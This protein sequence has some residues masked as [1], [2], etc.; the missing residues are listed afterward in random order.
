MNI[1]GYLQ[2]IG[3]ALMVPVATLPAAAILV[4]VGYWI[5]PTGWGSDNSLAALLISSGNAILENMAILF[6]VG[7]A[8]GM[9]KDKD[10]A[11]ALTGLVGFM[12][13]LK[14]CS[15]AVIAMIKNI[16]V[17]EVPIA[18]S[19]I[20]NQFIGILVG[21]ISAE[22]YNRYSHIEL[23][24]AL[25]FF[26]GRRLVPIL[27]SFLM[28]LLSFVLMFVWPVIY[29]WLVA[30]GESII[31]L[32][33]TGA[34]L[35]AFFNR[36]LIPIG[37]HHALNSVFWFDVAGINDIPNFL[38]GAK[39]IAEGTAVPGITGR[40]QAG[41]F[42]IM[43]F[44]LPGAALA[45][46]HGA[47]PENRAMV[48][49]IMMAGAFA[50]FFTGVTEPLEFS[51]MFVAPVLY[52]L[53][54]IMTGISV[55]IAATMHWIAGFG[56]SAGFTDLLLS[57]RNPLAVHWYMLIPQGLVFFCLY[58]VIFRFTIKK[59]NLMTLGREP[60][61]IGQ[62]DGHNVGIAVKVSDTEQIQEVAYKYIAAIG[63]S[64]NL[65]GIDSCITRLRL[66][67]KDAGLV[68]E[69]V[70]K[71]LGASGIIRLNKES[72]QIIVGTR[73][74]LIA[75]A[76]KEVLSK[77]PVAAVTENDNSESDIPAEKKY[78][79]QGKDILTLIAPVTGKLIKLEDVPD[80]AFSSKLVGDGIA[81]KPTSDTVFSPI[82]GTVVK[83][84]DTNHALC[85]EADNGVEVI[86]H[87]GVDT[88]SLQGK[89][90]ER[91]VEEGVRVKV[92]EPLLKLDLEYLNTHAKSMISPIIISNIDDYAGVSIMAERHVIAK[93]SNLFQ[94]MK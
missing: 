20:N 27:N 53:H 65:T 89:G 90:F 77:G 60:S 23:P 21:V 73:A 62:I 5:D 48:G 8:Y 74:E 29:S 50:A 49:G 24:Q 86:I 38:A 54:A 9:S 81:I 84:F 52:V 47:R 87:M 10:G 69:Q 46:Y 2:R 92:G 35:Y 15:P 25:S 66:S 28:I 59:F 39:S 70:T 55:Y 75:S 31:N 7:I 26:S 56:F 4:G 51:F 14:L 6:A 12:V 61:F 37:L 19:K 45:I 58:Y 3:R 64:G 76:M 30:F 83:I 88:V 85:I 72:I 91:L 93:E 42:P 78:K 94:V 80:E 71:R 68:N 36:L 63:G 67:V 18:F 32:G 57:S 79:P 1:L 16:P 17:A 13:V 22:L 34:G 11:A 82:S 33:S 41:F 43:M 40:Y 44:G